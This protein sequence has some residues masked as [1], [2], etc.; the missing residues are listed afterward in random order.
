MRLRISA[1]ST[2][3]WQVLLDA[4]VLEGGIV[5][6]IVYSDVNLVCLDAALLCSILRRSIRPAAR[7]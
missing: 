4:F 2:R 3:R 7:G 5:L 1:G 6:Y